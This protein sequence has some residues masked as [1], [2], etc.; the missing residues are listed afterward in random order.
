M[1]FFT[2][3]LRSLRF[4]ARSH[5]GVVLG[6][7]VGSAALVGALVVGD[8]VRGSLHEM[9]LARLGN[10]DVALSGGDRFFRD[11]LNVAADSSRCAPLLQVSGTAASPDGSAR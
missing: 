4:H 9:A 1:T 2:L 8:S 10:V 6:A 7:I 11:G 5:V 3:V